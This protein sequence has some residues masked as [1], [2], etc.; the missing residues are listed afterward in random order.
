ME[1]FPYQEEGVKFLSQ[2]RRALLLDEPG[3]GKTL[4]ILHAAETVAADRE[5]PTDLG[6]IGPASIRTQWRA[7]YKKMGFHTRH[8]N[9]Y[10]YEH[11]R[12]K[13]I[14]DC[15]ILG[16][17]E[18]HFLKNAS[19][20]RTRIILGNAL[21]GAAGLIINSEYVWYASGTPMPKDASDLYAPLYAITP[22]A[23]R[24]DKGTMGYWEFVRRFCELEEGFG[25]RVVIAGSKNLEELKDRIAPYSLRRKRHWKHPLI[26]ELWLDAGSSMKELRKLEDTG[27]GRLL[28]E[29]FA[30]GGMEAVEGLTTSVATLRRYLGMIKILPVA[31]WLEDYLK[32]GVAKVVVMCYHREVIKGMHDELHGRDIKSVIYQGGLTDAAKDKVKSDFIDGKECRVFLGQIDACGTGLDGLQHAASDIIF[33]EWS[34]VDDQNKQAIGR[35][36]RIGQKGS[37]LVRFVGMEDSLDGDIMRAARRRAADNKTFFNEGD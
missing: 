23:L 31:N 16:L 3:T 25:G 18:G 37:V 22:G 24:T 8:F 7:E 26:T 17:D 5:K 13:G 14:K 27:E 20:G 10:S 4:Q 28:K 2:R 29:A 9:A 36:D 30:A 11:A 6:I 12:D 32:S 34:W 1:L 33:A 35:V 15:A 19:S 21:Y